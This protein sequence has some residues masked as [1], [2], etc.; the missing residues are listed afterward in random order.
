MIAIAPLLTIIA[1]GSFGDRPAVLPPPPFQELASVAEQVRR[2]WVGQRADAVIGQTAGVL[3]QLPGQHASAGVGR[4]HAIR[5]L[6]GVFRRTEELETRVVS[7][8]EVGPG[9][10]YVELVRRYRLSGTEEERTQRVLLAFR[11]GPEGG[12]WG[13]VELRVVEGGG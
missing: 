11:R 7:S 10:G 13:L 2:S 4:D 12:R 8:R 3:I 6:S 9:Q 5:L 1:L